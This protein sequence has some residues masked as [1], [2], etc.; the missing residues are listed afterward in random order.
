[1]STSIRVE[2]DFGSLNS[3]VIPSLTRATVARAKLR[4][5]TFCSGCNVLSAIWAALRIEMVVF[6]EPKIAAVV[7]ERRDGYQLNVAKHKEMFVPGM[8][9]GDNHTKSITIEKKSKDRYLVVFECYDQ[10]NV[11]FETT[12]S[13][14]W[15][16]GFGEWDFE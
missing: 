14:E 9:V 12:F 5:K 3:L 11:D 1:M 15:N 4:N 7:V 16:K 2:I 13:I 8:C 10:T 6:P